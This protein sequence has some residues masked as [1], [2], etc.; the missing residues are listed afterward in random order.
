M[1]ARGILATEGHTLSVRRR[2]VN[3]VQ[4]IFGH[5]TWREGLWVGA[6][7]A[8]A[9]LG[10]LAGLKVL[11]TLLD[12]ETYGQFALLLGL[13]AFGSGLVCAPFIQAALRFFPEASHQDGGLAM[14]R[15]TIRLLTQGV[16]GVAALLCLGGILW[17]SLGSGHVPYS[18]F[19]YA[20]CFLAADTWK[21]LEASLLNAARRQAACSIRIVAD[22]LARPLAA[23]AMIALVGAQSAA[24][25]AGYAL[26][27][28]A[29]S[30]LLAKWTVRGDASVTSSQHNGWSPSRQQAFVRYALPLAP[31][32]A[33]NWVVSLGPRYVL[34]GITGTQA[35]GLYAA[36]FA[37]ASQP[38]V[39]ANQIVHTTLR[40][41]LYEAVAR[42]DRAKERRTLWIWLGV[43]V[44]LSS[45][46]VAAFALLASWITGVLLG[47]EFRDASELVPWIA[48][49]Y[50]LQGVQQTFEVMM[51][52]HG[53]T[54]RLVLL[55]AIAAV[56]A[57]TLYL[58][59]IPHYGAMGAAL[60]TLISFVVTSI[61]AAVL[62]DAPQRLR[63]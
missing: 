60:G 15:A 52:A 46:G 3:A 35:V 51:Y 6:G 30:F 59:L 57:A 32:A 42:G 34:G 22:G 38:F 61:T 56:T 4:Q 7:Q 41:I 11:T 45:A 55:Q 16:L 8:A 49:A 33:L 53:Q 48:L 18:N 36:A 58:L 31:L 37:L 23:V 27:S 25:L 17:N 19:I 26:G 50:A 28:G 20:A 14:R 12:V 44:G 62:A 63:R 5:R 54:Q 47:R 43:V 39:A 10:G 21:T 24:A 13:V 1:A 9:V 29:V 40:P 2:S